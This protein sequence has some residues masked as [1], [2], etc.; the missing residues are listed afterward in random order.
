M[1]HSAPLCR[2]PCKW[3]IWAPSQRCPQRHP[4]F[5]SLKRRGAS[6]AQ[7]VLT[8][9]INSSWLQR[10]IWP[11]IMLHIR[12]D[13]FFSFRKERNQIQ[14]RIPTSVLQILKLFLTWL[15]FFPSSCHLAFC[16]RSISLFE[17]SLFFFFYIKWLKIKPLMVQTGHTLYPQPG[18]WGTEQKAF[19][20]VKNLK[21]ASRS[22]F[23]FWS[24]TTTSI[25]SSCNHDAF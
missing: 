20:W 19:C 24:T 8:C 15:R 23:R 6:R 17:V 2:D 4:C 22:K 5:L 1:T 10:L 18:A 3:F 11:H 25:G 14:L 12:R 16:S 13:V 9:S 21:A 7:P